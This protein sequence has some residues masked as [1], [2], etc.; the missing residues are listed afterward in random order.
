MAE[1]NKQNCQY[2]RH[3][4][5]ITIPKQKEYR[6]TIPSRTRWETNFRTAILK[7]ELNLKMKT[8]GVS[9]LS[10][11]LKMIQILRS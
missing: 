5:D 1:E 8:K 4:T 2:I 10:F 7:H 3:F 9:D 6:R 11:Y